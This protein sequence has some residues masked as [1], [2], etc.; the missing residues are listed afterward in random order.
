MG[1]DLRQWPITTLLAVS[2]LVDCGEK[3]F[4]TPR[5]FL[6]KADI[7]MARAGVYIASDALAADESC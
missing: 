7:G 5:Y 2:A 4:R 1:Q 3:L 6:A